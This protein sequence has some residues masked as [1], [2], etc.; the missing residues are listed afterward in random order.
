MRIRIPGPTRGRGG[1]TLLEMSVAALLSALMAVLLANFWWGFQQASAEV[2]ARCQLGKEADMAFVS[3]AD[4]LRRR[5]APTA[6]I[7]EELQLIY[8]AD[9]IWIQHGSSGWWVWYQ[10]ESASELGPARLIRLD[11]AADETTVAWHVVGLE[12]AEASAT[13]LKL[14]GDRF[15]T[16]QAGSALRITLW[17]GLPVVEDRDT[18]RTLI[19]E[20]SLITVLP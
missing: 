2:I 12:V 9:Q 5:H 6:A 7:H 15:E 19:R 11:S 18:G 8:E 3:I 1:F 4:D 14:P 17:L 20:Y 16:T 13:A 10:V